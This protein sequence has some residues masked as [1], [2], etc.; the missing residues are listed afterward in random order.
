MAVRITRT[1]DA[2]ETILQVDGQLRFE[3]VDELAREY[4]SVQGPL[5][6]ELSNLQSA[7]T[8][9]VE[10]LLELASM[11]AEIRGVSPYVDL[12]LR[13]ES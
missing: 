3:D 8:V 9:G 2:D 4:R 7:D 1:M 11:G 10:T 13:K 6:L 12:L 5:V